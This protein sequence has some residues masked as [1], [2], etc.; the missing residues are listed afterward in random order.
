MSAV[1]PHVCGCIECEYDRRRS[2]PQFRMRFPDGQWYDPRQYNVGVKEQCRAVIFGL[3]HAKWA[4]ALTGVPVEGA[5]L[6][7]VQSIR[8]WPEEPKS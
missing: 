6:A 7:A 8:L 5:E 3:R 1:T 4:K 2:T